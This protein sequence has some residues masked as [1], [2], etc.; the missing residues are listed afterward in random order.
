MDSG[1]N[2]IIGADGRPLAFLKKEFPSLRFI[3]F[4]G[5]NISYPSNGSMTIKMLFLS[6]RILIGIR[7]EHKQVEKIIKEYN[8]DIL[9]SD[10]RYGVWSKSVKCIFIT[11]QLSIQIPKWLNLFKKRI[12]KINKHYIDRF[13]ECW[14]PDLKKGLNL[15]GRLSDNYSLF[16]NVVFIGLLSRFNNNNDVAK[17]EN[18]YDIL[19]IISGPEPQRT[20]FEDIVLEQ[21]INNNSLKILIIR[22]ITESDEVKHISENIT[23]INNLGTNELMDMILVSS[24]IISRPGYSSIMDMVTLGK[25]A[26]LVPTPGK[27]NR[28]I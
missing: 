17:P 26:V 21:A 25:N 2:V 4:P 8:I 9:I 7:R 6:P 15:S 12:F 19:F 16:N 22:G 3:N 11:H 10:N 13:T 5:Y 23:M 14:V 1:A 20:I 18:I 27:Q 24:L 28:Y